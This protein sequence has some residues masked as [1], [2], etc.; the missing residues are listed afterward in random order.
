MTPLTQDRPRA[1]AVK[2]TL[3][4][5]EQSDTQLS[6]SLGHRLKETVDVARVILGCAP[7]INYGENGSNVGIGQMFYV[8]NFH[9]RPVP[10][11][12]TMCLDAEDRFAEVAATIGLDANGQID[13]DKDPRVTM[14]LMRKLKLDE[15]PQALK[16]LCER[17][18]NEANRTF[19][20]VGNRA[21]TQ[22]RMDEVGHDERTQGLLKEHRFGLLP[23][24]HF[25]PEHATQQD[26]AATE[27]RVALIQKELGCTR[28]SLYFLGRL[29]TGN[30]LLL[31]K[32]NRERLT[33]PVE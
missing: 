31:S 26:L 4:S 11:L 30:S 10:K 19:T 20:M 28:A 13:A 1:S 6:V 18:K 27:R 5:K 29:M 22:K 23:M 32:K 12:R 8:R 14:P 9:G 25:L 21:L 17:F 16:W 24:I 3:A 33:E 7:R 2:T 15:L